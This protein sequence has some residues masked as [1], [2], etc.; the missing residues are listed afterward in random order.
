LSSAQSALGRITAAASIQIRHVGTFGNL[1]HDCATSLTASTQQRMASFISTTMFQQ[2]MK[3]HQQSAAAAC[4]H[5]VRNVMD[6]VNAAIQWCRDDPQVDIA[7]KMGRL[8]EMCTLQALKLVPPTYW[9][10]MWAARLNRILS[11]GIGQLLALPLEIWPPAVFWVLCKGLV[12]TFWPI[13]RLLFIIVMPSLNQLH[14]CA[15]YTAFRAS[16]DWAELLLS[17]KVLALVEVVILARIGKWLVRA[18]HVVSSA[19]V[20]G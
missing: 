9:A 17:E 19:L 5:F 11:I 4:R 2:L 13:I 18:S 20:T 14:N 8:L 16:K 7:Q 1:L 6:L 3:G 12:Y 15:R 10:C